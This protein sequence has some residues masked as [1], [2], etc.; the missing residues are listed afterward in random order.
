MEI[1]RD[2]SRRPQNAQAETVARNIVRVGEQFFAVWKEAREFASRNR[3]ALDGHFDLR[4]RRERRN[5]I[6]RTVG[7]LAGRNRGGL[8]PILLLFPVLRRSMG[9]DHH[10]ITAARLGLRGSQHHRRQQRHGCRRRPA[11]Q[12]P[13]AMRDHVDRIKNVE[14]E[15]EQSQQPRLT[16]VRLVAKEKMTDLVKQKS[17]DCQEN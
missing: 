12:T 6:V 11:D 3:P 7:P 17:M 4:R 8:G 9:P 10:V 16:N 13:D 2:L 1:A 15:E 14:P 5:G